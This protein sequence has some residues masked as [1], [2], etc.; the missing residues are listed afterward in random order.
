MLD[1][2]LNHS[3]TILIYG[4]MAFLFLMAMYLLVNR[5]FTTEEEEELTKMEIFEQS[6]NAA[7]RLALTIFTNDDGR[8]KTVSVIY[9]SESDVKD[10][11]DFVINIKNARVVAYTT[12]ELEFTTQEKRQKKKVIKTAFY[13]LD[14]ANVSYV[15]IADTLIAKTNSDNIDEDRYEILS[16]IEDVFVVE[17]QKLSKIS[18]VD[19]SN[20][21]IINTGVISES[22]Q[23]M[24]ISNLKALE[25]PE[26]PICD[27]MSFSLTD[28]DSGRE[29]NTYKFTTKIK[30]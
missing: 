14:D 5:Y 17:R 15:I 8:F 3:E 13:L 12:N 7:A 19:F 25:C 10:D 6:L 4:L 22:A 9:A 30:D 1:N 2:N 29:F 20:L 16:R 24:I 21:L 27:L 28:I 23:D 26:A 18:K 11:L